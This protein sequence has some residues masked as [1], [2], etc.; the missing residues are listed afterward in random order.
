MNE[1]FT[2]EPLT[3]QYLIVQADLGGAELEN[4]GIFLLDS[5]SD[6]LYFRFRR[7]FSDLAGE[8]A[9]WFEHL[10]EDVAAQSLE[11]GARRYLDWCESTWSNMLRLSQRES[12]L[13]DSYDKT[14]NRLYAAHVQAKVL[15]FRTHLPQYRLRAAAGGFGEQIEIEPPECW[16]EVPPQI[17][18]TQAMFVVHV[19]GHSMEPLIPDDSLCVFQQTGDS[20]CGEKP[21]LLQRYG[22]PGG[23][24]Y[25]IK[26]YH[27]AKDQGPTRRDGDGW[28]HERITLESLNPIY[29]PW[30][31]MSDSPTRVIG[32]LV[33][34]L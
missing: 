6:L 34:V 23:N 9:E 18:L 3:E 31:L 21:V 22:E 25:S 5:D 26:L 10:A 33:T 7:D 16:V 4:I 32:E 27:R 17:T 8:E 29:P 14:V 1:Q 2:K 12:V 15:A 24:R 11:F 20:P 13:V 19:V 30:D 28:L